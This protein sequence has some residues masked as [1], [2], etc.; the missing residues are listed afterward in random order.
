MH[1]CK[2]KGSQAK[3]EPLEPILSQMDERL[4]SPVEHTFTLVTR[5]L[6]LRDAI[7][8]ELNEGLSAAVQETP[9]E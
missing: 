6:L 7:D 1:T 2:Q 5:A 9:D 8:P 3:L 4:M